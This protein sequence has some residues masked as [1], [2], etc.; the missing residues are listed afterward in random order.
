MGAHR[1]TIRS[2]L[3]KI[4]SL[5]NHKL[6]LTLGLFLF[7]IIHNFA[8]FQSTHFFAG[9]DAGVHLTSVRSLIEGTDNSTY[10]YPSEE[11]PL[12]Q[13]LFHLTAA[14]FSKMISPENFIEISRVISILAF[15]LASLFLYLSIRRFTDEI[16]A[17]LGAVIFN[18]SSAYQALL[19]GG[20]L[21]QIFGIFILNLFIYLTL[22]FSHRSLLLRSFIILIGLLILYKTHE[23]AF[24]IGAALGITYLL[25]EL[26][27]Y[28]KK[29]FLATCGVGIT[30]FVFVLF[31]ELA[32]HLPSYIGGSL[33]EHSAGIYGYFTTSEGIPQLLLFLFT[34]G[35]I[36]L[37]VRRHW[38]FLAIFALVFTIV[39]AGILEM[40]VYPGRYMVYF[41][42]IFAVISMFGLY[43]VFQG[44]AWMLKRYYSKGFFIIHILFFVVVFSILV[45]LAQF[46][47][48]LAERYQVYNYF[49]PLI[50]KE[51][52]IAIEWLDANL[53][54][55]VLI[56][57]P[58]KWGIYIPPIS[59][60]AVVLYPYIGVIGDFI[61]EMGLL[62]KAESAAE[63]YEQA[64]KLG[65]THVFIPSAVENFTFTTYYDD[66][67]YRFDSFE[68]N[69]Y[70]NVVYAKDYAYILEVR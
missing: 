47:L 59:G 32:N 54:D 22:R 42:E 66:L 50:P 19:W 40:A 12:R 37:I 36:A 45:P 3:P 6:L 4:L 51:D 13:Q 52:V 64:Q 24:S 26:F 10:F 21:S 25:I 41:F 15:S 69:Y 56:A 38:R 48:V 53:A 46:E 18:L 44:I 27:H 1:S 61:N 68:D 9:D 70:F 35:I 23:L 2:Y 16:P 39:N 49:P 34:F 31:S 67:G 17:I 30:P 7:L 60:R 58:M 63:A 8:F 62:F 65:V 5:K 29:L 57:A 28:S 11:M 33:T 55:D 43:E 14:A 20:Q